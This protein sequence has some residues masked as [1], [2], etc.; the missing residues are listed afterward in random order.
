MVDSKKDSGSLKLLGG[1]LCLDFVNTVDWRGTENPREFLNCYHDLVLWSRHVGIIADPQAEFLFQTAAGLK[2]EAETVLHRALALRDVLYR[3]FSAVIEG[4][5]PANKDLAAFNEHLAKT[6]MLSRI[7]ETK[8]GFHWDTS[9]NKTELDWILRPIVRSAADLL[10]S[11]EV[12]KAKS[13]A[14]P[15]CG[16]L[17]L[18]TSRNRSRRW[19]DMQDCGNRAKASRFYKKIKCRRRNP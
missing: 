9:G 17:F 4:R 19:C 12:K 2:S 3:I 5:K 13:C 11:K 10:V 7:I 16:W 1:S 8:D 15:A 6:M 18:D 14:A